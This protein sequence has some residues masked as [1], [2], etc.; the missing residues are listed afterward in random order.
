VTVFD[1][2]ECRPSRFFL[3]SK[4]VTSALRLRARA[5]RFS[6]NSHL[7]FSAQTVEAASYAGKASA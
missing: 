4:Y 6:R 7:Q 3:P 1:I 2:I 5:K